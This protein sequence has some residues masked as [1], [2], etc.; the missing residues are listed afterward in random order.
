MEMTTLMTTEFTGNTS[1][2]GTDVMTTEGT[3]EG[4]TSYYDNTTTPI[5]YIDIHEAFEHRICLTNETRCKT[6]IKSF[7]PREGRFYLTNYR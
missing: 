2:W 7:A 1:E 5:P 6:C 3:T 4:T